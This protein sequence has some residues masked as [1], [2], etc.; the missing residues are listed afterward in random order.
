MGDVLGRLVEGE[1][2][3]LCEGIAVG[4]VDGEIENGD[5]MNTLSAAI[6]APASAACPAPITRASSPAVT[7]AR[8]CDVSSAT[9]CPCDKSS[10]MAPSAR[11]TSPNTE[12]VTRKMIST[13]WSSGA[14]T[15]GDTLG[16]AAAVCSRRV[17]R[18]PLPSATRLD[19]HT[20]PQSGE[21]ACT[22]FTL[23]GATPAIVPAMAP[24]TASV[25][26][27]PGSIVGKLVGDPLGIRVVGHG[28]GAFDG[29][30][31]GAFDGHG[32]GAFD[33]KGVGA[34]EGQGVGTG[35]GNGLGCCVGH[36]AWKQ[37]WYSV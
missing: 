8:N 29:H 20:P 15:D 32:V 36:G 26:V 27:A 9:I 4:D 24:S 19:V 22:T 11:C 37:H 34:F 30:G 17:L 7:A 21:H 10:A 3:G 31:V 2:D 6:A 35:L 12:A 33:G 18:P 14:R 28:V 1:E 13:T 16:L 23:A 25:S 5:S